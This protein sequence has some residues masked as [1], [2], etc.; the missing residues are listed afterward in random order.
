[1]TRLITALNAVTATTTSSS[2]NVE[3]AEKVVFQFTRSAHGSG[4]SAFTVEGSVDG[5]TT[6]A[7]LACLRDNVTGINTLVAT[8]V[9]S[10]NGTAFVAL[11]LETGFAFTNIRVTATETTDGTHTAVVFIEE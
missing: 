11:D 10:A 4:S 3:Y 9:L 2:I 7:T 8:K 1:M 6:W 5:G